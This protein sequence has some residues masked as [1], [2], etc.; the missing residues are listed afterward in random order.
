MG[1]TSASLEASGGE[2]RRA[3]ERPSNPWK[4]P[5][6]PNADGAPTVRN[7]IPWRDMEK[8]LAER[9]AAKAARGELTGELEKDSDVP[10]KRPPWKNDVEPAPDSGVRTSESGPA[11]ELT[12]SVYT[13]ADLDSRGQARSTRMSM[14]AAPPL[15]APPS[16][17]LETGRAALALLRVGVAH[18]KAPKPRPRLR[19]VCR[20]PMQLFLT[21]LTI[22]LRSMPWKRLAV[23]AGVALGT[24]VVLLFIVLTAAELTD[25]LK[26]AR[27][28]TTSA[29]PTSPAIVSTV[30]APNTVAAPKPVEMKPAQ[31][32][33]PAAETA[34]TIEI[35][36]DGPA[37]LAPRP[38]PKAKKPAA[39]K[40]GVELFKP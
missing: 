19:D 25:D 14:V 18:L 9:L 32:P 22:S 39:K 38:K 29:A 26:P 6:G 33:T 35:D 15:A 28:T 31:A 17:W 10:S 36:D 30:A 37:A 23:G 11:R 13:V 27:T 1:R 24:F 2:E 8:K 5:S 3:G 21:E 40:K 12:Y 7:L 4:R 34:Q 16:R 20:V